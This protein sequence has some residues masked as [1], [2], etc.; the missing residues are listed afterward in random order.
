MLRHL[1]VLFL[2]VGTSGCGPADSTSGPGGVTVEDAA[3][4]DIAAEK[5]DTDAQGLPEKN[6]AK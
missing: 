6:P 2:C 5:L 4:L 3:A 1:A